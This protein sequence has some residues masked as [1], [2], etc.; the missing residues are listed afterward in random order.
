MH[1]H[2]KWHG[3]AAPNGHVGSHAA[4]HAAVLHRAAPPPSAALGSAVAW[5][6]SPRVS[7]GIL[8]GLGAA[9]VVLHRV[10]GG[11]PLLLVALVSGVLFERLLLTPLG[12][13]ALRF[14]SRPALTL[15]TAVS[16]EAL[17]VTP[18][19][20][21]G[22]GIVQIDLDGQLV[23]VLATLTRRDRELGH[24]VRAGETVRVEDVDPE[25]NR[26]RVT[27]L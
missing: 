9:G 20:A 21:D 8:L 24:R 14:A 12:N 2:A 1:G 5:L 10:L 19:D 18:F 27:L 23:Q 6:L 26:C 11:A 4:A 16:A 15:E 25:R 13:L 17:A 3:H 22:H 7:F